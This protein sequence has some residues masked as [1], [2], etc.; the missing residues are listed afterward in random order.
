MPAAFA[1][2]DGPRDVAMPP[3]SHI[4]NESAIRFVRTS[5]ADTVE[6]CSYIQNMIRR[7]VPKK[8]PA[9]YLRE[10]MEEKG[11]TGR[12]AQVR[13]MELTG[14]SKATMSQLYND[15][16][17]LNSELLRMAAK[18]LEI[19]QHELLMPPA[20]AKAYREFEKSAR[21]VAALDRKA[22]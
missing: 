11:L 19:E 20:V 5:Y 10:W 2:A 16:Q 3:C 4:T 6:R 22:M 12:G 17:D 1:R 21:Q 13:M 9:W 8:T 15:Q 7:G 18:A 14:W